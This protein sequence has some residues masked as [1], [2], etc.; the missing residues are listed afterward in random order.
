MARTLPLVIAAFLTGLGAGYL[1]RPDRAPARSAVRT[2]P[3]APL[4]PEART[5]GGPLRSIPEGLAAAPVD[6]IP[7]GEGRITGSVT[8]PR[9]RPV[10][11]ALVVAVPHYDWSAAPEAKRRRGGAAPPSLDWDLKEAVRT[12]VAYYRWMHEAQRRARTDAE[13]RYRIE[14]LAPGK[15]SLTA[16][17]EGR[18]IMAKPGSNASQAAD[19]DRIDFVVYPL[20]EIPVDVR[21]P[22][23]TRPRKASIRCL[24]R[25]ES[26][27]SGRSQMWTAEER[28]IELRPG[29]YELTALVVQ[30]DR[31]L[32]SASQAIVVKAGES[33]PELV[34]ALKERSSLLVRAVL[35]PGFAPQPVRIYAAG[36]YGDASRPP[37][38]LLTRGLHSGAR[39]I[40][41]METRW[42]D[43]LP[44]A[45][46]VGA[47]FTDTKKI[48][49]SRVVEVRSGTTT[50]P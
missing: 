41:E 5:G 19:G 44:G 9:G 28:W 20:V 15:H 10:S 25:S 46:L 40:K 4:E 17:V 23:G 36:L 32:R 27:S 26:G 48:D 43:L 8:D 34:F 21:L 49:V 35:P 42:S 13:G 39:R 24:Q 16:Y 50:T 18:E 29:G 22:G 31:T 11:G 3:L 30:G 7:T 6:P 1:L 14:R 45:Y 38:S 33:P 2:V 37:E 12:R 47:S